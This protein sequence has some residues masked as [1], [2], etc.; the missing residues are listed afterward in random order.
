MPD[1]RRRQ[2]ATMSTEE[3]TKLIRKL[4]DQHKMGWQQ[5]A[6]KLGIAK[7]TAINAYKHGATW[8][9]PPLPGD[10]TDQRPP[11]EKW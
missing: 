2:P 6:D 5:I 8:P 7:S 4:R 1:Y 11:Q 3:R 10:T 9:Q